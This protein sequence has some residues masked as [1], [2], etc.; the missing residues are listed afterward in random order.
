MKIVGITGL[1][2]SGKSTVSNY[3]R[4]KGYVIIDADDI[5]RNITK[6]K[7]IGYDAIV[8][9]FGQEVVGFDKE[10]DRSK[11]ANIVF[12]DKNKLQELNFIMH[13][14]IFAEIEEQIKKNSDKDIVFLDIPL[15]FETGRNNSCDDIILVYCDEKTQIERIKNRDGK[16]EN[17]A[18]KIISSQLDKNYK[19]QKSDYIIENNCS[20]D[21]VYKKIDILLEM[22]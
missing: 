20:I 21:D 14:I 4:K 8:K 12:S 9:H 7:N 5:S 17:I 1:I 16:D 6:Y 18:K 13:P 2:A 22:I 3:I 19:I 15:L 11:I 10:L